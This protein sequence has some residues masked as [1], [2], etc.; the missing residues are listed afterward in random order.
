MLNGATTVV[1]DQDYSTLGRLPDT[2]RAAVVKPDASRV[3]TFDA[4]AGS[5]SGEL[6]TFD[7]TSPTVD[8]RF[9]QIGAGVPMSP[10]SG[11]G[12][13]EMVITPDGGTIFVVG[14]AGVWVQPAP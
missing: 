1:V 2:T 5:E 14:I 7:L 10:G 13:I 11:T 4:P 12:A 9:Q 3:Y 6:R 8:G